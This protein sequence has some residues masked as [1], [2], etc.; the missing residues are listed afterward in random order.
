TV[1]L[2]YVQNGYPLKIRK[3]A[4]V[5]RTL[6]DQLLKEKADFLLYKVLRVDTAVCLLKCSGHGHCDPI[7]KSC[8]C[9]PFW[10]ENLIQRYFREG[11]SNC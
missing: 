4:D 2:F 11:E 3:A 1:I 9:Y 8:L 6:Q 5:T 10:M 7:T